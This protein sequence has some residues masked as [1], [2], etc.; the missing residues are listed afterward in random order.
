MVALLY[1][2]ILCFYNVAM[3]TLK[4]NKIYCVMIKKLLLTVFLVLVQTVVF[5]Q[6]VGNYRSNG[7][8]VSFTSSSNWQTWNGTGWVNATSAPTSA[9]SLNSITIQ[10][11][12]VAN[13][14]GTIA[15]SGNLVIS[16]TVNLQDGS[17]LTLGSNSSWGSITVS[18]G[19]LF[20]MPTGSGLA[21]LVLYGNYF[22]YGSTDFCKSWVVITGDIISPSSSAIQNQ[23]NVAV[24]GN[25]IGAFDLQG[26]TN[27]NQIYA[28]NPNATIEI[29]PQSIDNTVIAGV[30]PGTSSENATYVALVNSII[31]GSSGCP[32]VGN[33]AN[34]TACSG[35]N[36]TFSVSFSSFPTTGT[37]AYQWEVN[38]NN[39]SGWVSMGVTTPTLTLTNVT[40]AMN[41]Y[42]YRAKIT[43][44]GCIKNGNYG[45]LTV[46]AAPTTPAAGAVTQPTCATAT[47]TFQIAAFDAA[48]TYIFTPAV[49]SISGTGLV[50]ANA[51]T[52]TFTVNN[53][54]GCISPDS[55]NIGITAFAPVDNIWSG[56]AWSLGTPIAE[57]NIIFNA[58]ALVNSNLVACSC[59]AN[60]DVTVNSGYNITLTKGLT[61][62]K[63]PI[64]NTFYDIVF[65]SGSSLVQINN[66]LNSG[67]IKYERD[68]FSRNTDYTYFSSPVSPQ[69]LFDLSPLSLPGT[70]YSYEPTASSEDWSQVASSTT[71]LAGKG[72]IVRGPEAPGGA[73]TVPTTAF[74]VAFIGVPNNGDIPISVFSGKSYL[75]GNPY[76]S[77]INADAFLLANNT[78]LEGT[79]Y[80]W[81]HYTQMGTSVSNPGTG[82]LAY[83]QDDYASY[84]T[85]GGVGTGNTI[86]GATPSDPRIEVTANK[87]TGKIAAGQGFFATSIAAGTVNF[88]NTMRIAGNNT[89]FFKTRNSKTEKVIEKNRVWL[90]LTN[91]QGAFKQTLIGYVTDATNDY[92][93]R[94]D[95]ESFDGNEFVDFYSVNQNKNLVIQGRALPFDE[96]DEVPLGY[97]TTINGA[98]TINID[99]VDGLLSNQAVFLEDKL[100]NTVTDL[101]SGN[102]TFNT[103]PGTFNER[104]VL[105]Y[106]NT[107]KSLGTTSLNTQV[108]TVL[109]SNKNKQIK[110]NSFAETIDKV[111]I[112]DLLGRQI[113]QKEKVNSNELSIANLVSSRQTLVVKTVLQN[114]TTFTE[115]I[116]Y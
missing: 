22:N 42:K 100:T 105:R 30:V 69:T 35:T 63:R 49:V 25:V 52:Y 95:G 109:V 76:P 115:K 16:G 24:G 106:T 9:S 37:P 88:T 92:D 45:V 112:Y 23:G 74:K 57:Q 58:F 64:I 111:T 28:V 80:F 47:G 18:L 86:A 65:E 43:W 79:I 1:A 29:T 51:G 116:I 20:Q 85:T 89:Q 33:T 101:K 107:N 38:M 67:D 13:V 56:S 75:L 55:A 97:R 114:G 54:S 50:T 94:F 26:S 102:Y 104:F 70:F 108:N 48:R 10:S 17:M 8:P 84:N 93:S 81:T 59:Q 62:S 71:M 46:N 60:A 73:Q 53:A 34:V 66:V 82:A 90:N 21:T 32:F 6:T 61:V 15:I 110:I 19:G 44:N 3:S 11:G 31:F 41:S 99:Q 2:Y 72:Y 103:I 12:H 96:N 91:T 68:T 5:G 113:Y 36:A 7:T 40:L 4:N 83:S 98:F 77:A 27:S 39:G 14:S 87:P 78:F